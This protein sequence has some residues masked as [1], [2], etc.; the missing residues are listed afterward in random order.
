MAAAGGAAAAVAGV[1]G[2]GTA[3]AG[4]PQTLVGTWY[5]VYK[6]TPGD[7]L[8]GMW[9]FHADGT[10]V[11]TGSDHLTRTP[12]H[13]YWISLGNNQ[14]ASSV[15]GINIDSAGNFAG[16]T[17]VD[18][19]VTLDPTG[20]IQNNISRVS[21]YDASGNLTGTTTSVATARRLSLVRR[22]DP[23]QSMTP[24]GS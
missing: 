17:A 14:F 19:D 13:G 16:T 21:F 20:T 10:L 22:S 1:A 3:S 5:A 18:T 7:Q 11:T 23:P 2:A 12:S 4:A 15:V 9:T 8:A 6:R 24:S